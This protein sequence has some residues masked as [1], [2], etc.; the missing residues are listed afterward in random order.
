MKTPTLN[1]NLK[2]CDCLSYTKTE[3]TH[4]TDC[5]STPILIPCPI[6]RSVTFEV[7]LGEC[8]CAA[9]EAISMGRY[10][11]RV[12]PHD[13]TNAA[14]PAKPLKVSCSISGKT[15]GVSFVSD[16]EVRGVPG[17]AIQHIGAAGERWALVKALVLGNPL[18]AYAGWVG[19]SL[20]PVRALFAQRDAVFSALA[21]M[22]RAEETAF[23]AQIAVDSEIPRHRSLGIGHAVE[24][25]Q[26]PSSVRL[27]AYVERLVEQVQVLR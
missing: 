12:V 9:R 25:D 19:Q 26:R 17:R 15:W 10:S 8:T 22:A 5:A 21:D 27:A 11:H 4:M 18:T 24:P 14:C 2:P 20:T 13:P 1:V 16:V 23:R 7:M 6:P 3:G